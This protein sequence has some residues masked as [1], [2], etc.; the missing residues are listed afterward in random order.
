M[1]LARFVLKIVAASLATAAMVCCLIAYWDMIM[2]FFCGAKE[3]VCQKAKS[4][5]C[6]FPSEYDDYADW[7][8]E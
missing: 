4:C 8:M 6:H 7:E 5:S 1:K 3:K 2:D